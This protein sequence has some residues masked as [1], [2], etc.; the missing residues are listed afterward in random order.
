MVPGYKKKI[1]TIGW[2]SCA[3]VACQ[4]QLEVL[5][6]SLLDPQEKV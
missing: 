2:V 3:H 6:R 5:S 4:V 1:G